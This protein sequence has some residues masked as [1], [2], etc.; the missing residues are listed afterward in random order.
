[1]IRPARPKG[2]I[3]PMQPRIALRPGIGAG[4]AGCIAAELANVTRGLALPPVQAH[5]DV[6]LLQ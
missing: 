5:Q 1:M 6:T 3:D 2:F 4:H